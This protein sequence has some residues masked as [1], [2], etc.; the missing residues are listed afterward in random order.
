MTVSNNEF[1]QIKPFFSNK[2][3]HAYLLEIENSNTPIEIAKYIL[4]YFDNNKKNPENL[5]Y[6]IDNNLYSDLTIIKP[7]GRWIKKEQI[8][9]LQSKYRDKSLYNN[10]RIYIINFAEDLNKSSANTL[11]KFLEEPNH[12]IIALLITKNKY[13]VL[14]TIRSR[15]Q[16]I[17]ISVKNDVIDEKYHDAMRMCELLE[18]YQLDSFLHLEEILIK[19]KDRNDFILL[20]IKLA[21]VYNNLLTGIIFD[22]ECLLTDQNEIYGILKE[23]NNVKGLIRKI[24]SLIEFSD[25]LDYNIN[26]KLGL[27]KLIISMFGVDEVV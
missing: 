16:Y 3:G 5:E 15:C 22:N 12:D 7:D 9:S 14:E 21:D 11:L 6:L 18:T 24:V 27:D 19:Y 1:L 17:N 4:K 2:I 8:L 13:R 25:A 26:I 20:L 23:K 10:K